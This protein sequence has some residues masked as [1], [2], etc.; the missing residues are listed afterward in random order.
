MT[1]ALF[2]S[3]PSAPLAP[4]LVSKRRVSTRYLSMVISWSPSDSNGGSLLKGYRLVSASNLNSTYEIIYDG[5]NRNETY[6]FA[7]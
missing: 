6:E 1:I 5:S 4:I 2:A 3:L 7:H